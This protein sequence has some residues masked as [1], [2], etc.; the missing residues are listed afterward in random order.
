MSLVTPTHTPRKL[1]KT[2][3]PDTVLVSANTNKEE[4]CNFCLTVAYTVYSYEYTIPPSV[5]PVLFYWNELGVTINY[6]L[7][8]TYLLLL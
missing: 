3:A 4:K 8:S 2:E 7:F 6:R 5:V 1:T